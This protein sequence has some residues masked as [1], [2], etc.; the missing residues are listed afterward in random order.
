MTV[1]H[2][3][4]IDAPAALAAAVLHDTIEDTTTD[5]DDLVSRFG[6][7]VADCVAALSKD[8]RL[9]ESER[10]PAYLRQLLAGDWRVTVCKLADCY[11]NVSD[12]GALTPEGRQKQVR[13][14]EKYLR[15]VDPHVPIEARPSFAIVSAKLASLRLN[16]A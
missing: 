8:M 5:Y 14:V 10:E 13:S 2:V 1:R 4:G 16:D 3:F 12:F 9:P 15:A 6:C 11:D 7:V